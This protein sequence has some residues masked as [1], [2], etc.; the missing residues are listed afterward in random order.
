MYFQRGPKWL[1]DK[2][3]LN[4]F[5][6]VWRKN[7]AWRGLQRKENTNQYLLQVKIVSRSISHGNHSTD[8]LRIF[9]NPHRQLIN[10]RCWRPKPF[11]PC[12]FSSKI[13]RISFLLI[14]MKRLCEKVQ[15]FNSAIVNSKPNAEKRGLRRTDIIVELRIRNWVNLL[16][17]VQLRSIKVVRFQTAFTSRF[18]SFVLHTVK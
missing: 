18:R 6:E 1:K 7:E 5:N 12:P 17:L 10:S 2:I 15:L 9:N 16:I 8:I 11:P 3:E 4:I 14:S 13:F